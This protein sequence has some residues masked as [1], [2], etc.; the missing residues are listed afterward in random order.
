MP[1]VT[2]PE[3]TVTADQLASAIDAGVERALARQAT[4]TAAQAPPVPTVAGFL[5]AVVAAATTGTRRTYETYWRK[6]V[7]AHGD[8]LVSEVSTSQCAALAR[9]A[10]ATAVQRANSRGGSSAEENCVAALRA[11]FRLVVA[12]KHRPDNPALGVS[13]PRRKS[14][15]RRGLTASEQ[16]ELW[17]VTVGGGDDILLDALLHRFH[18]ETGAR[19]GGA[20]ALRLR[21]LDPKDQLILLREKGET[22]RWQPVSKTLLDALTLHAQAR[23]ATAPDDAVLRYKPKAGQTVGAPLTRRRYNTLAERWQEA[24]P[25]AAR[26]HVSA[27]WL[28]HTATT[29]VERLAGVA[30]AKAFAG[31]DTPAGNAITAQYTK[32]STSEVAAAVAILTGEPHPL[33]DPD[34]LAKYAVA[35][36]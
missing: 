14:N 34:D 24:L 12:D 29:K 25:W 22:E 20:L 2:S 6:L 19:R 9:A 15:H 13:K 27:H 1:P 35:D 31:H 4:A 26:L 21:D 32:A 23:G 8:L 36:E 18:L 5:D 3:F 7:D 33:A 30:V 10:K 28:R 17:A 16:A 11:F